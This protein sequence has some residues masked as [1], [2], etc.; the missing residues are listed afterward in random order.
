VIP[1]VSLLIM[2]LW[3]LATEAAAS[4]CDGAIPRVDLIGQIELAALQQVQ[5]IRGALRA[6]LPKPE[7]RV[8]FDSIDTRIDEYD[9]DFFGVYSTKEGD[10]RSVHISAAYLVLSYMMDA[11][12]SK[13]LIESPFDPGRFTEQIVAYAQYLVNAYGKARDQWSLGDTPICIKTFNQWSGMTSDD[14]YNWVVKFGNDPK[15]VNISL[16]LARSTVTFVLGHEYAHHLLGHLDKANLGL[17][18]EIAADRYALEWA[19]KAGLPS[20]GALGSFTIAEVME[21]EY[22]NKIPADHPLAACRMIRAFFFEYSS[23]RTSPT[24]KELENDAN[25]LALETFM[26]AHWKQMVEFQKTC[27]VGATE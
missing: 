16:G 4:Q 7:Q 19:N 3:S 8:L 2:V 21:K 27:N 12:Y 9:S 17:M 6:V 5:Y 22:Q 15:L 23:L 14:I 20:A 13:L 26:S 1:L 25:F 11:A 24:M 18:E 10:R